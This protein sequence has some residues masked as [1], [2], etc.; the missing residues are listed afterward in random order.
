M[1]SANTVLNRLL[2]RCLVDQF[3]DVRVNRR[4]ER[5]V[6]RT[7]A[8][9]LTGKPCRTVLRWGESY[10]VEC[11]LCRGSDLAI[12]YEYAQPDPA[13]GRP[14]T[15]L[16]TCFANHC[17]RVPA[18]RVA[19]A[20]WL[21]ADQLAEATIQEY[22]VA[23]GNSAATLPEPT[24]PLAELPDDHPARRLVARF[25]PDPARA[26]NAYG[27]A[28]AGAAADPSARNRLVIP[29]HSGESLCGWQALA[30][31]APGATRP[32]YTSSPGLIAGRHVYNLDAALEFQTPV[33]VPNPPLVWAVGQ[34][35]VCPLGTRVTDA[36]IERL[37]AA[38]R[39]RPVA[40][41]HPAGRYDRR[42]WLRLLQALRRACPGDLVV[43][44]VPEDPPR[45]PALRTFFRDQFR[46]MGDEHDVAVE[47]KRK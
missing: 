27:L 8:H 24:T 46:A 25:H 3:G 30:V 4:G 12:S 37:V 1:G 14:M 33:I 20:D 11:P 16:A 35:A 41:L 36:Q 19:L 29:I 18:N 45:G 26:G 47:F 23:D 44:T 32:A 38:V 22:V 5:R 40:L 2:Y 34:M 28:Y 10:V 42:G 43:M 6:V 13:T 9:L 17:L 15:F 21:R 39:G 7:G 31:G